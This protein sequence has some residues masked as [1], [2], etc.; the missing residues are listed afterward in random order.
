M[1]VETKQ[2]GVRLE[3][4]TN[5]NST[6]TGGTVL[7]NVEIHRTLSSTGSA[8]APSTDD[9][10]SI[11]TV[12]HKAALVIH[13]DLLPNDGAYRW[14]RVRHTLEGWSPSTWMAEVWGAKPVELPSVD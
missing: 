8:T 1:A 4:D 5:Y 3:I 2:Y 6:A 14:Y 12:T 13:D 9:W 7:S 11:A 10:T